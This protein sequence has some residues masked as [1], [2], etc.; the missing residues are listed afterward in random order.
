MPITAAVTI[1][2]N[3]P[4]FTCQAAAMLGVAEAITATS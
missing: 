2:R 1:Q 4:G 3:S